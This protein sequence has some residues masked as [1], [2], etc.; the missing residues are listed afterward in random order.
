[1]IRTAV[2]TLALLIGPVARGDDGPA[3][4]KVCM[5]SGSAEYESDASLTKLVDYLEARYPVRCT[6]LKA[7]GESS[8]PGLEAL[9]DCDVALFFTR[10]LT[11]DG[12]ALERMKRYATSGRPIV[13][14][15]TAS[16]GFQNWLEFDKLVLGGNYKG[17]FGKDLIARATTAPGAEG[18]PVL[19]GVGPI[20]S[21]GSLYRTAP[22]AADATP[23]LVGTAPEGTEPVTWAREVNGGRVV[24]T[25][26]GAQGDFD[27]ASFLRLVA[28]AL[29]WAAR[30]EPTPA[31]DAEQPPLRP[32]QAGTI[33]LPMRSRVE[34]FKGS[35]RWDEVAIA[36][37]FP[38]A[39][40]AIL[41]CDVWDDHW[42]R[43]AAGR[44]GALAKRIDPMLAAA[45][46][47]GVQVIH[48]PSEC[49]GFYAGTPE[50][51][52][53]EL[54][55]KA[56]R[57]APRE[58][59]DVPPLPIDDA[60]G[61]CDTDEQPHAAW[62]RQDPA[63]AVGPLD[64]VSDSGDEIDALLRQ[65]GVKNVFMMGVHTNMCVLNRTFGLRQMARRGY[66]CVLVRD[67]TDAMYDPRDRPYVSHD[68]GTALV[69]GHIES[70]LAPSAT[71]ADL[72][73]GLAGAR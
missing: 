10:R 49:M 20:A 34:S 17:H 29:F 13:G 68:E 40:T 15:R 9:D 31:A 11:I 36:R 44:C 65:L 37:E 18:H 3:P 2:A 63:I 25:S 33:R 73:A 67:L 58:A 26:I 50:R 8:L 5:L 46:T 41:V 23:L 72:L 27:N 43:G 48:A 7:E 69:V 39:E 14:I 45:R 70:Y 57:R 61:G 42:C 62:T 6:L 59:G 54:A 30:R 12:E 47:A 1:M 55:P 52:R 32:A 53:A 56:P 71:S 22:L 38:A 16:H 24:Y 35:G 28:N 64:A 4:L 60:D 51:L 19:A 66:D 21:R